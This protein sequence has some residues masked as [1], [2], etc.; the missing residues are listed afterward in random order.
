MDYKSSIMRFV[1]V[2][3]INLIVG[4]SLLRMHAGAYVRL[5]VPL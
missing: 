2:V 3:A 1:I 4:S 5:F